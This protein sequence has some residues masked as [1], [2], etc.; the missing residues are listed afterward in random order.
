M[1]SAFHVAVSNAKDACKP[2][3]GQLFEGSSCVYT[4][5]ECQ[6]CGIV[7]HGQRKQNELIRLS[8]A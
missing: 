2:L 8:L 4:K 6:L 5:G 7:L 1:F 3:V